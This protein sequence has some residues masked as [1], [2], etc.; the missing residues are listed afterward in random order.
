[1]I[2]PFVFKFSTFLLVLALVAG[3]SWQQQ[4]AAPGADAYADTYRVGCPGMKGPKE[5]KTLGQ[6]VRFY[7]GYALRQLSGKIGLNGGC[8]KGYTPQE[9]KRFSQARLS[10]DGRAIFL[11]ANS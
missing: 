5:I 10:S 1:M 3:Q 7:D 11:L 4:A 2:M 6:M 9:L 8:A